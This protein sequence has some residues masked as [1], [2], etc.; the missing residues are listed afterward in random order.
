MEGVQLDDGSPL[1][2]YAGF[3]PVA[4]NPPQG[5]SLDPVDYQGTLSMTTT[6]GASA[7]VT[8]SG[9]RLTRTMRDGRLT[10]LQALPSSSLV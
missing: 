9:E 8:F 5:I 4:S 2:S 6:E 7:S 1:V 3:A 10:V